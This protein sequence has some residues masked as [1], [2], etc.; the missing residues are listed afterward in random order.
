MIPYTDIHSLLRRVKQHIITANSR[1]GDI[2][3]RNA[4][5]DELERVHHLLLDVEDMMWDGEYE[6]ADPTDTYTMR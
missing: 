1:L 5:L 6:K 2:D 4:I 3:N